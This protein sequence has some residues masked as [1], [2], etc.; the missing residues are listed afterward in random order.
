MPLKLVCVTGQKPVQL[1]CLRT[2]NSQSR[3]LLVRG[4]G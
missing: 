3:T 2:L 4:K 1:L